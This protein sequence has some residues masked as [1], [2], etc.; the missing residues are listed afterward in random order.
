M[1]ISNFLIELVR[2]YDQVC[3]ENLQDRSDFLLA[4]RFEHLNVAMAHGTAGYCEGGWY[5]KQ[6]SKSERRM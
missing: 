2:D 4:L 3:I 5:S 1:K 6:R